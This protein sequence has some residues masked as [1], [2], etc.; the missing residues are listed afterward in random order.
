MPDPLRFYLD[1]CLRVEVA[2]ALRQ[3]GHDVVRAAE[4]GQERADDYRVMQ[5]AIIDSS[6]KR[7]TSALRCISRSL[8][9]T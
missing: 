6:V 9:R 1:Q 8:R 7:P 5:R 4:V 3:E 2:E